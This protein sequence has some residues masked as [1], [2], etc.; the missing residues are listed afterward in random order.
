M[1]YTLPLLAALALTVPAAAQD[2]APNVLEALREAGYTEGVPDVESLII[3]VDSQG[4]RRQGTIDGP[5]VPPL[6]TIEGMQFEKNRLNIERRARLAQLE[7]FL[8]PG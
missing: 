6:E 7:Q 8:E 1:K 5:V 4:N 2:P 3:V